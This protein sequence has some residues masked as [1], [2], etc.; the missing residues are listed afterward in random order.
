[1]DGKL[2]NT[3]IIKSEFNGAGEILPYYYFLKNKWADRMIFLHDSM[4]INRLFTDDELEGVKFHWHFNKEKPTRKIEQFISLL[5][6]NK[7]LQDYYNDPDSKWKG[8]FGATSIIDLD[9]VIYIEDK[10]NIFS[11][12]N[13]YIKTR[14]DR[15]SF[16]RILGIVLYHEGIIEDKCSNFGDIF[17]YPGA[18]ESENIDNTLYTMGQK[19]Y[20][21]AII[22]VWRGR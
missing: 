12:L 8:C 22:K 21:T 14:I 10:Y 4:F 1:M 13:L 15:E 9:T 6:N 3:E 16:E 19:G 20:N 5:Q 2:L 17:R 7:E 18:F 11:T